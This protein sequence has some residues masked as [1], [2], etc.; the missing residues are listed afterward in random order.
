MGDAVADVD[1]LRDR[2]RLA[3]EEDDILHGVSLDEVVL[4]L[5]DRFA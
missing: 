2:L 5:A 4:D 3:F 1:A